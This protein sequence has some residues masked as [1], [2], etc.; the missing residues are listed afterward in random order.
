MNETGEQKE[1]IQLLNRFESNFYGAV[2][3]KLFI[4]EVNIIPQPAMDMLVDAIIT[5]PDVANEI[6]TQAKWIVGRAAEFREAA[7]SPRRPRFLRALADTPNITNRPDRVPVF[8]SAVIKALA[9]RLK[10]LGLK[11]GLSVDEICTAS[12]D[13]ADDKVTTLT[14]QTADQ[15]ADATR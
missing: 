10:T 6:F 14:T 3:N 15:A 12:K 2:G 11:L 7:K 8:A 9:L 4:D 5:N 13:A 1:L